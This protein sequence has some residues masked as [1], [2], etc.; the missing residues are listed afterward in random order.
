MRA[1]RLFVTRG[2]LLAAALLALCCRS[3]AVA[4]APMAAP[5]P[6][7]TPSVSCRA[8]GPLATGTRLN[9]T[10]Q[11]G[12]RERSFLLSLPPDF[13][14]SQPSLLLALHGAGTKAEEFLDG[15][16]RALGSHRG[17]LGPQGCLRQC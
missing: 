12:G 16:A 10:L 11:S 3:P 6:T 8:S 15:G 4:Q 1:G 13:Q 5:A 17:I 14:T 7:P 2:A 9:V